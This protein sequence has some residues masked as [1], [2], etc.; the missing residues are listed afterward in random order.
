M[1]TLGRRTFLQLLPASLLRARD[2]L[3]DVAVIGGGVGGCAA[4]IAACRNGMRVVMTEETDWIG[5]QLTSQA[6]PLDEHPWIEDFGCTARYRAL[7]EGIREHYR[8]RY[9]L[10]A[11]A[12]ARR[13]LNP[14]SATVS[15]LSCDP[16]AALAVL[17]A[18]VDRAGIEV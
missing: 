17:E 1:R 5:G 16:R 4:A 10:T 3:C 9:P 14:G 11:A 13:D 12:R 2:L 15:R 18:L 8:R 7:R 6:V